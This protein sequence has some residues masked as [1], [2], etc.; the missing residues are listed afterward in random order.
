MVEGIVL[1]YIE[2][3]RK[4]GLESDADRVRAALDEIMAVVKEAKA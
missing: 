2:N 3:L 1:R 4:V